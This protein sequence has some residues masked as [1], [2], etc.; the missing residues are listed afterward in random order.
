MR[1]GTVLLLLLLALFGSGFLLDRSLN[2]T[3][4]LTAT[5]EQLA[6]LQAQQRTIE[7]Q[8]Q[9]LLTENDRLTQ[10]VSGLTVENEDLRTR[11]EAMQ[12]QR[13]ELNDQIALLQNQLDVAQAANHVLDPLTNASAGR[14]AL[15]LLIV[16][17]LP[18]SLGAA[19]I[20]THPKVTHVAKQPK[21]R[22]DDHETFQ[23]AVTREE[24]HM[25][26]QRRRFA[27]HEKT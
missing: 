2:L 10:Q 26:S 22:T 11:L 14:I 20:M 6:Q 13:K 1:I 16:P 17:I 23:A 18:L 27:A 24:L 8:Y 4:D 5:Q 15:G 12:G 21:A 25:I 9:A 19:Y 7:A 3:E